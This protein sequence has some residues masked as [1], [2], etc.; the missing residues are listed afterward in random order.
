MPRWASLQG[1]GQQYG[2]TGYEVDWTTY[3]GTIMKY[4]LL[5]LLIIIST[6]TIAQTIWT[7][8][9]RI[10]RCTPTVNGT[11]VCM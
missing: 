5:A 4:Y 7:P 1:Y 2:S 11:I 3:K 8:D 10:V 6:S 9:G